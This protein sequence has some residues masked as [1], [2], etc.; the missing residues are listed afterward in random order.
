MRGTQP[1]T[2]SAAPSPRVRPE[3][4]A[5]FTDH[6]GRTV[7][8]THGWARDQFNIAIFPP[9]DAGDP[10]AGKPILI[11]SRQ[12]P[13]LVNAMFQLLA[14]AQDPVTLRHLGLPDQ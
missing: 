13:D 7:Y 1:T 14:F 6:K 3:D 8:I 2:P 11:P 12:L 4:C 9:T 5:E 10:L